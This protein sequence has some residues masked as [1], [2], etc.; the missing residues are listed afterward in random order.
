MKTYTI[1][2]PEDFEDEEKIQ[3]VETP[4]FQRGRSQY[5][6]VNRT[7]PQRPSTNDNTEKTIDFSSLD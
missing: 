7:I 3:Q 6:Q 2:N 5:S 4:T 1:L